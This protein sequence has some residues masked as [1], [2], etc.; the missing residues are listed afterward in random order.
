M[1]KKVKI[2]EDNKNNVTYHGQEETEFRTQA[3]D[4]TI[5]EDKVWLAFFLGCE[6][7]GNLLSSHWQHRQLNAVEFVEAAPAARLSK[8]WPAKTKKKKKKKERKKSK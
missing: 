6:N 8:T 2:K 5:S 1:C 4:V 7:N 3:N